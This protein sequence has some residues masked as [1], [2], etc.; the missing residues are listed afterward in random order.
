LLATDVVKCGLVGLI[1][2]IAASDRL[3]DGRKLN[4]W[5][6]RIFASITPFDRLLH[7]GHVQ[8]YTYGYFYFIQSGA[9]LA[10]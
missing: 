8:N 5:L 9:R 2:L 4:F 6:A 1:A 3:W 10:F 7:S